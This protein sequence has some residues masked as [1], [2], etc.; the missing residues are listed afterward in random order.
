MTRADFAPLL[1]YAAIKNR[2]ETNILAP[3]RAVPSVRLCVAYR[4]DGLAG[5]SL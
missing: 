2:Q 4:P 3:A 1:A 5:G